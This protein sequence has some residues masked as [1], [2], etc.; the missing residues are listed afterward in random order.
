[1]VVIRVIYPAMDDFKLMRIY[2]IALGQSL[3]VSNLA[4]KIMQEDWDTLVLNSGGVEQ[5]VIDG[6][7]VT[8]VQDMR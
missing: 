2:E 5:D 1:M 6:F 7:G 8:E 4:S 3:A